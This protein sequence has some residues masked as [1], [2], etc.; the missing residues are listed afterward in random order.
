M[1]S[2]KVIAATGLNTP[3]NNAN[4]TYLPD[5]VS[6]EILDMVDERRREQSRV[7]HDDKQT[8]TPLD[9]GGG[10]TDH[11]IDLSATGINTTGYTVDSA[12]Y[13]IIYRR[14]GSNPQGRLNLDIGGVVYDFYPGA[15][16]KGYFTKA[17]AIRSARSSTVGP[18]RLVVL[19]RSDAEFIEPSVELPGEPVSPVDLLGNSV[20]PTWV[21]VPENTQPAGATPAGS[22]ITTG[23][24]TIRLLLDI[25]DGTAGTS[26]DIVPW[27]RE[28]NSGLWFEQGTQRVSIPDSDTT[29]YRYRVVTFDTFGAA[30]MYFQ[31]VL[32]LPAGVVNIN[33]IAQGLR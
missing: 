5:R 1:R 10:F 23:W 31:P 9:K 32:V 15:A 2:A 4:P 18:A 30:R 25:N 20:T 24:K 26:L 14:E 8:P 33:Q 29:A 11:L 22:F 19:G 13:G 12:G 28:P 7:Q 27:V 17:T 16:I 3:A 6:A 21:T